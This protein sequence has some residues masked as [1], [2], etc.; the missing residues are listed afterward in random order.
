[1]AQ[2]W[3]QICRNPAV[4]LGN[5]APNIG[6]VVAIE[7]AKPGQ[8]FPVFLALNSG[9]CVG[10]GYFPATFAPFKLIPAA[11]GIPDTTNPDDPTGAAGGRFSQMY[12]QLQ[13]LDG[14]LRVNSP[15]GKPP[16]DYNDF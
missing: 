1:V 14:P 5:I 9:A 13:A 4:A 7:K 15:Y 3:T 8:L 6:S 16:E 12:M 2:H 10:N 11:S